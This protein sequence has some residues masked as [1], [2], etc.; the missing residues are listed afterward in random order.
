[1]KRLVFT[2]AALF[3]PL[4]AA[5]QEATLNGTVTDSTG[6][7][8]PESPFKPCMRHLA[9][10]SMAVTDGRG[11]FRLPVRVGT[12]RSPS[13]FRDS[14]PS[15]KHGVEVLVGQTATVNLQMSPSTRGRDDHGHRAESPLIETTSSRCRRQHRSAAGDGAAVAGP[16][17]DVAGAARAGQPH[18]R[19]GRDCRCRTAATS[20]NSS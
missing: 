4:A 15:P 11:A 10:R 6:A 12:T 19:A 9:I 8:F 14:R 18:Q 5:A 20:A 13:S 17:L 1:M 2:L 16:Q 3:L 7:C